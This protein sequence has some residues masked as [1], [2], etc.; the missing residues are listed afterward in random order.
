MSGEPLELDPAGLELRR[1]VIGPFVDSALAQADDFDGPLQEVIT[2]HAWG[3][4]W[5]REGL[6]PAVRSMATVAMLTALNR[7]YELELHLAGALR[8]G[9]S[10]EEIRELLL[11]CSV[12]CGMPAA[13]DAFRIARR[14]LNEFQRQQGTER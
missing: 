13:V 3:R 9:C 11:H 7:P 12:Y 8:N 1:Q 14:V 5:R 2:N 4:I 6:S 10:P